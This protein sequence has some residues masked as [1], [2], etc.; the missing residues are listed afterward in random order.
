MLAE[1]LK[2]IENPASAQPETQSANDTAT[3][4]VAEEGA[5]TTDAPN[6]ETDNTATAT[7]DDTKPAETATESESGK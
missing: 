3:E 4:T 2:A 6:A 5:T 7:A 1:K